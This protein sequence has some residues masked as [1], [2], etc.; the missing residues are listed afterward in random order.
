MP[1]STSIPG[2][3]GD[4]GNGGTDTYDKL[5]VTNNGNGTNVKIGDD[6]WIGDVDIANHISIKGVED[7]TL[8]GI[9]F[10]SDKTER[11]TS[12][13]NDL[14]L[15]ANNDILLAA[16]S[17][18]GYLGS[19]TIPNRLAKWSQTLIKKSSVPAHNYGAAGDTAGMFTYDATY[20]YI[21]TADYVNNTTVIW[22]RI[23]WASGNW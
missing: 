18:Y 20:L 13:S 23:N 16:G 22:Q 9:I 1:F 21:C 12:N 19:V 10:G 17:G 7:A 14:T 15:T 2:P 5:Y 6:A 8:G 3:K 4:A 11:I